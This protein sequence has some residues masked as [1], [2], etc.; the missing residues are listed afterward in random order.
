VTDK[1][2]FVTTPRWLGSRPA[3]LRRDR[4]GMGLRCSGWDSDCGEQEWGVLRGAWLQQVQSGDGPNLLALPMPRATAMASSMAG[5][6]KAREGEAR[7]EPA[8][9][10]AAAAGRWRQSW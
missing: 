10:A 7:A 1:S 3:A 8:A 6:S 4:I 2:G 5:W 9:A